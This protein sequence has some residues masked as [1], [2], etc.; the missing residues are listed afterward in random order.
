MVKV[1]EYPLALLLLLHLGLLYVLP[2]SDNPYWQ[3]VV[4]CI[5]E[6]SIPML[7]F[8]RKRNVAAPSFNR[9][10]LVMF[11]VF[12][13]L[14]QGV[15]LNYDHNINQ[16]F[17]ESVELSDVVPQVD[18]LST[19]FLHHQF[20]YAPIAFGKPTAQW[21]MPPTYMPMQWM[22]Y[23]LAVSWHVDVRWFALW[24]CSVSIL[25]FVWKMRTLISREYALLLCLLPIPLALSIWNLDAIKTVEAGIAALYLLI[26]VFIWRKQYHAVGLLIT[27]CLLS[28]FS[29]LYWVPFYLLVMF[30]KE[31]RLAFLQ[32]G[33]MVLGIIALYVLPFL[34]Q[35]PTIFMDAM[36]YHTLA[37]IG[38]WSHMNKEGLPCHLFNG[39][40]LAFLF[41]MIQ[42]YSLESRI[43]LV[44]TMQ[45]A[46]SMILLLSFFIYYVKRRNHPSFNLERFLILSYMLFLVLFYTFM[47]IP[48]KYLFLVP[49]MVLISGSVCLRLPDWKRG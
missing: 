20:P 22:P 32:L 23:C 5:V 31:K 8:Y 43:F 41:Y 12:I 44:Q 47:Q 34:L 26:P 36:H 42:G 25:F 49:A 37:S 39:Q 6:L 27:L 28:R 2:L 10:Q 11:V 4:L 45:F 21:F 40:G 3:H 1:R 29:I 17:P 35:H 38:E 30:V 7:A 33:M 19:R 18:S 14:M 24:L 48:Y 13:I 46:T 9:R 16:H 15:V